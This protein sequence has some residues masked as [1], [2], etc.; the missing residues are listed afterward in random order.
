MILSLW[1]AR[2]SLGDALPPDLSPQHN[3]AI[4]S[5]PRKTN[6][7]LQASPL[8]VRPHVNSSPPRPLASPHHPPVVSRSLTDISLV[9]SLSV[10][11]VA[12]RSRLSSS[13]A[14][15]LSNV[16]FVRLPRTSSPI[17]ASSPLPLVLC[18]SPLRL[19]SFRSSRTPT[20]APF[21]LSVSLSVSPL[22]HR[23]T[24]S[25]TNNVAESKDIQLA[26]RL[27]G[28]RS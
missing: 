15:Y 16:W 14:S 26:R 9:P 5:P 12:T 17:C 27:R 4:L 24:T 25:V 11:S 18:K 8:V 3:F 1:S 19:T 7:A 28:E 2:R 23:I 20:C 21:T 22:N 6:T 10:R 13:S